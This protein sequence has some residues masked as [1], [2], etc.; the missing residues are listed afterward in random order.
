MKKNLKGKMLLS[1]ITLGLAVS[2]TIG[3]TYAWFAINNS[4]EVSGLDMS[5]TSGSGIWI[6][7]YDSTSTTGSETKPYAATMTIKN[8]DGAEWVPVTPYN[9]TYDATT[10]TGTKLN[11]ATWAVKGFQ[12]LD[13]S[14]TISSGAWKYTDASSTDTTV[15]EGT[16]AYGKTNGSHNFAYFYK[17]PV[18]YRVSAGYNPLVNIKNLK[19]YDNES[20]LIKVGTDVTDATADSTASAKI[21]GKQ[22][23]EKLIRIAFVDNQATATGDKTSTVYKITSEEADNDYA[24]AGINMLAGNKLTSDTYTAKY[25]DDGHEISMTSPSVIDGQDYY[26]GETTIYVWYEGTDKACSN[27]VLQQ[28]VTFDLEFT[29]KARS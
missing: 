12:T 5:V 9:G 8:K 16:Y 7:E 22:T 10:K 26:V 21:K 15:Y 6:R 3:S 28:K 17:I 14:S 18:Q 20:K 29:A 13:L 1:C 23:A 4:S 27:A 11:D 19:V 25:I 2:S 24:L